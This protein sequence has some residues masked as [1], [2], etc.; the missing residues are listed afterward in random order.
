MERA[1]KGLNVEIGKRLKEVRDNLG[2]TQS[3]FAEIL[4]VG[5]EHYR[6]IEL[7]STGLTIDKL[8]ILHKQLNIDAT[9][10]VAGEKRENADID[11]LLTNCTKV[12]R[13]AI[14][15]RMFEYT[16]SVIRGEK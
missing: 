1:K 16:E 2:Y 5:E 12:E 8:W 11:Y 15:H 4:G 10:L 13:D 9:Y 14:L 3:Q 6:K 7:G